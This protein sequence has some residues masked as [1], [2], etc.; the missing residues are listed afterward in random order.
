MQHL[1][2][3]ILY[4]YDDGALAADE[5]RAAASH[6]RD[7][8][9]CR[10]RLERAHAVKH[11][12]HTQLSQ[13]RAPQALRASI[14]GRIAAQAASRAPRPAPARSWFRVAAPGAA[15]SILVA[16]LFFLAVRYMQPASLLAQLAQAHAEVS[17]DPMPLQVRGDSSAVGVWFARSLRL[18]TDIPAIAGMPL[19]GGRLAQIE[20]R[21]AAQVVYQQAGGATMSLM[22]WRGSEPLTEFTSQTY[23]GGRF[24]VG[25]RGAETIVIWPVGDVRY[26]CVSAAPADIVRDMAGKVRHGVGG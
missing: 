17:Q 7:C 1:A 22:I 6:L 11:A 4:A 10:S 15:A 25:T 19:V 26:A 12:L 13:A 20:G 21:P 24:Y 23:E 2:D 3:D 5:H 18:Q 14:R 8:T 9:R 16:A